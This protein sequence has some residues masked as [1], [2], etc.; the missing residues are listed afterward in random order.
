VTNTKKKKNK[1][2]RLGVGSGYAQ[3]AARR[4]TWS[5]TPDMASCFA[6]HISG[7]DSRF[8]GRRAPSS[9]SSSVRWT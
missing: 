3:R 8:A 5:T 6:S 2:H 7:D 1:K 4:G 9:R